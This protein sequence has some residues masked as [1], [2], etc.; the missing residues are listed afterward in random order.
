MDVTITVKAKTIDNAK[1]TLL[2]A[3]VKNALPLG[4][5]ATFDCRMTDKIETP[6]KK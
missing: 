1:A 4:I 6:D 2:I 5:Y 3:A